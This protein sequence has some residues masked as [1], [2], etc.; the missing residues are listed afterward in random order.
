VSKGNYLICGD[1]VVEY[2]PE[3]KH[4]PRPWG[5]G[6]NPKTALDVFLKENKRFE[7]DS[8]IEN[9]LLLSCNPTGYLV[10]KK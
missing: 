3:Q 4:R 10:A 2:L 8:T 7:M 1:T 9:K 6:N 5:P